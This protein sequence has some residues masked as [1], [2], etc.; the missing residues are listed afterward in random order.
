[1]EKNKVL[2]Y[3]CPLQMMAKHT[4]TIVAVLQALKY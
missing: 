3:L 4:L 2:Y 1:M